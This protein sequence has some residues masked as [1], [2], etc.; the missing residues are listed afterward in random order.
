ML[1]W[2]WHSE[3]VGVLVA[4]GQ[5]TA[6]LLRHLEGGRWLVTESARPGVLP[7]LEIPV[8]GRVFDTEALARGVGGQVGQER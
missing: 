2:R 5:R 4:T 1:T 8:K 3:L 6:Y 7:L